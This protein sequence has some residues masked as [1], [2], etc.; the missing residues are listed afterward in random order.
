ML[1]G[2]RFSAEKDGGSTIGM[3]LVVLMVT[4]ATFDPALDPMYGM[5]ARTRRAIGSIKSFC[6]SA[7][8]RRNVFPPPT[9]IASA[10]STAAAGRPV[11]S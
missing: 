3:S 8:S 10:R 4:H 11:A 7:S 2:T 6:Q 9:K 1:N 5:P